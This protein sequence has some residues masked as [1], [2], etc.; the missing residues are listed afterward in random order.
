MKILTSCSILISFAHLICAL[1]A[2]AQLELMSEDFDSYTTGVR[3]PD[4]PYVESTITGITPTKARKVV[5]NAT[6][7]PWV[8]PLRAERI[9]L[10]S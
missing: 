4:P 7:S 6:E 3:L 8:T 9:W 10:L 5:L 1:P 2:D